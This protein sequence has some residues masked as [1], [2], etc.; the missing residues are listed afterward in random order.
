MDTF[1]RDVRHVIRGLVARPTHAIIVIATLA[2]VTGATTA[3][4]AVVS[5]TLIRPL[6][7]PH[8][9]R[10]VQLF[11]MPPGPPDW[12]SRNPQSFG[13]FLRFRQNLKHT[14]LVEGLWSRERVVG[15][16]AE[17]EVVI[18][19]A[20]SPG[21]F[22]LFG[23]SPAR[24]RTFTDAEDQADAKVVVLGDGI[25]QRRFGADPAILGTTVL[26]DRE[27]HEVIGVMPP[28]FGA[29]FTRTDLWTPLSVTEA[30]V[31]SGNTTVQ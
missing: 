14:E 13:T 22:A 6:P 18:A 31:P 29:G 11:L 26:I 2:L 7:F 27:P 20:V 30:D 19:G 12:T 3:V 25:W 4:V 5:A 16:E 9:D 8:G 17:P 10:L 15:G 21:L 28:A 24:G 1:F 23:G